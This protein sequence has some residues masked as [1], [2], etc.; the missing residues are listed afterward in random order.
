MDDNAKFSGESILESHTVYRVRVAHVHTM[1]EGWR[2]S[3][4][5]VEATGEEV[6]YTEIRDHMEL[7]YRVGTDEAKRRNQLEREYNRGALA[8]PRE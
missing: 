3:E 7:A 4:T 5:T 8:T 6:D 1:K 2:L